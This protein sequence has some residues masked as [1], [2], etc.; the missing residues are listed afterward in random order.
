MARRE[1]VQ[2]RY[3]YNP[4]TRYIRLNE[5]LFLAL[6]ESNTIELSK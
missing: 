3:F 6:T 2:V 4:I 5:H 1:S